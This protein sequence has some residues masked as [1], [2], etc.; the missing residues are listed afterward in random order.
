MRI[1]RTI[2]RLSP[3]NIVVAAI[4]IALLISPL[5]ANNPFGGLLM[6]VYLTPVFI[7]GL[8]I[9]FVIQLFS[10]NY[11]WAI[12]IELFI[13]IVVLLVILSFQK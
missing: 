7:F 13:I 1:G 5:I 6:L 3:I 12:I 2:Y 10:K 8:I 9:D 11:R 4:V